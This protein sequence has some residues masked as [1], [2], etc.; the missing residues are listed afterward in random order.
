MGDVMRSF[1]FIA[2]VACARDPEPIAVGRGF[3][4]EDGVRCADIVAGAGAGVGKGAHVKVT[5][6]GWMANSP[7]DPA[8]SYPVSDAVLRP[9]SFSGVVGTGGKRAH[10]LDEILASGPQPMRPGGTRRCATA[11]ELAGLLGEGVPGWPDK[12]DLV[13]EVQLAKSE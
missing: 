12:T 5:T 6:T 9:A 4:L 13:V 3:V 1:L 8:K 7:A 11:P 2:L 10:L